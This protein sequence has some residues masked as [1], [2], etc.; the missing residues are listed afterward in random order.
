MDTEGQELG[1]CEPDPD[2][3]VLAAIERTIRHS[4]DSVWIVGVAKH[5]GFQRN[6]HNTRRLRVQLERL[7]VQHG[8]A[9]SEE[10]HGREYWWQTPAGERYLA[11]AR[12]RLGDLPQV[13]APNVPRL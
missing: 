2:V 4:T 13:A 8:W 1:P 5:L 3:L 10:R 12:G 11:P 9:A 7:R 6:A